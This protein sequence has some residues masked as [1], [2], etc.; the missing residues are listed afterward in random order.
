MSKNAWSPGPDQPVGE[1]VRVRVAPLA[2][3]RVDRLDLVRAHLV[4][5]LVGQRHDLV[6]ADAGL[7]G[8]D[9][10]LVDAV[11]HRR[12]L[13]SS[14]ISSCDLICR[15]SSMSCWASTTRQALPLHLE[16]ERRL[17]DVH[18]DRLVG[19][20]GLLQQPLDL[21]YRGLHQ[22]GRRGDRAAHA[23]HAGPAVSSGSQLRVQLVVPGGRAEVP[24]P[25]IG[26]LAGEQ[27]VAGHLVAER[28]ADPGLRRVADVVEVE[29]QER[30]ALA[31]L[32]GRRGPA[33]A[34]SAA[35]GRSRPAPRSRR[36]CVRVLAAAPRSS[37]HLVRSAEPVVD[38]D[39]LGL[40]RRGPESAP[41][42]RAGSRSPPRPGR[43]SRDA[44]TAA[45]SRP[46]PAS[47]RRARA[48]PR[49]RGRSPCAA[50]S[51]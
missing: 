2:R 17:D 41:A 26:V 25:G 47:A 50:G 24:E 30:P 22:P 43:C 49:S 42:G 14:M 12:G 10:V 20:A 51:G 28:A 40:Q 6:L 36:P 1:V 9:D 11:D 32:Q 35:A 34:G 16:Q 38:L 19:E 23:E 27:R 8:L 33:P 7:E 46:R 29:E 44:C 39:V 37:V 13:V 45:R 18:A 31:G 5:P 4:E 21:A 48:P 15:A 3:D